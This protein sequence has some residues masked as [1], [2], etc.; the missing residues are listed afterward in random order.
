MKNKKD[1][2]NS[3]QEWLAKFL[4]H[5]SPRNMFKLEKMMMSNLW[6][7]LHSIEYRDE[8]FILKHKYLFWKYGYKPIKMGSFVCEDTFVFETETEASNAHK[9]LE[10]ELGEMCGWWYGKESFIKA[11]NDAIKDGL[12]PMHIIWE[13]K[14]PTI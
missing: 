14:V 3:A 13:K 11:E 5:M 10:V 4:N 1:I 6:R 2:I 7:D 12:Y 9:L 8:I